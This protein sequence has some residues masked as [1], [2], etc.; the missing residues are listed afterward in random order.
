ML[1]LDYRDQWRHYP[2]VELEF[3]VRFGNR[4]AR[5][6]VRDSR[7]VGGTV[8]PLDAAG[9]GSAVLRLQYY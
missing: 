6:Y 9:L 5:V 8:K 3:V 4:L 1:W 7:G 2:L